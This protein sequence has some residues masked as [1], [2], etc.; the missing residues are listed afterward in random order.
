ME[1][2][3]L[4][5]VRLSMGLQQLRAELASSNVARA[6]T[7]GARARTIDFAGLEN[8]LAAYGE[9]RA[10]PADLSAGLHA[11]AALSPRDSSVEASSLGLDTQVAEMS[12]ASM[13]YQT[14]GEVL[15]RQFGLMRLAV[16]GRS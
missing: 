10:S 7:P 4:D 15:S 9:G 12:A 8:L 16:T 11:L 3:T 6:G 5:A 1:A 2:S 13:N 14:L